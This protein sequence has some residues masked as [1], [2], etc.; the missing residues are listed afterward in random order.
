MA[1]ETKLLVCGTNLQV[2]V[3]SSRIPGLYSGL[4]NVKQP[5]AKTRGLP[6]DR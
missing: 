3:T 1:S 5:S 6:G 2:P 4:K